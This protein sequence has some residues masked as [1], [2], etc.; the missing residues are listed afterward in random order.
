MTDATPGERVALP[1]PACSPDLETFHEVLKPGGQVTVRCTE[2]DHVH[3]TQLPEAS[4]IQRKV[5]VS[6]EGE[7][8]STQV[9]VPA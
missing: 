3:K 7:S 1:C 6:Q 8:F 9:D 4:E 2:C 5:V